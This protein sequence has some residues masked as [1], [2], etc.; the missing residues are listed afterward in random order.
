MITAPKPR[1]RYF[2]MLKGVA[3]FL[4]VMG[5]VLTFCVR[6]I[7]RAAIFK[8]I[9]QI[10]MPLF[11]FIS[12][13]FAVKLNEN[14]RLAV[15]KIMPRIVRLLLPMIVVSSLWVHYYPHSGLETPLVS[16]FEGLWTN[17]WKNGYWFTLVLFIIILIY[18]ALTPLLNLC[19]KFIADIIVA[20]TAEGLL[21]FAYN[22]MPYATSEILS[23]SLIVTFFPIFMVGVI[24]RKY[25]DGFMNIVHSSSW[26]TFA[27]LVFAFTLYTC[28]WRWEFNL[29]PVQVIPV[30]ILLHTSLVIIVL[31]VFEKWAEKAFAPNAKASNNRFARIWE[32]LGKQSLAIYMLHYFFLFPMGNFFRPMLE[33]FNV[34][35]VPLGVF[36]A[37]WACAI[38]TTV[39]G[40]VKLLEP[41]KLLSLLLYGNK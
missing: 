4:V 38:I 25:H 27:I 8:F 20:A 7:D 18:A 36:S 41:S 3:I 29:G 23:L 5:H 34:S 33:A 30:Q 10:H 28:S 19:R 2:D 12:G 15:P 1:L 37:F 40:M 14:E 39:L 13:W 24:A 32:Y 31:N 22:A 17:G 11:F 6:E 21:L 35:F 16:T 9:E 26:Q